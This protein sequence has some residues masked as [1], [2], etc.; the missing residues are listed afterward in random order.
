VIVV[1]KHDR[2]I[3]IRSFHAHARIDLSHRLLL[4]ISVVFD[5]LCY[6]TTTTRSVFIVSL[7]VHNTL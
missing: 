4:W 3:L 1:V 6:A 2:R 7:G 5:G